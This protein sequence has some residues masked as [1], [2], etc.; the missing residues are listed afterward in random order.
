MT[1]PS[2]KYMYSRLKVE[3]L[4][5]EL[6]L[7]E[8]DYFELEKIYYE[9]PP[10]SLLK[11]AMRWTIRNLFLLFLLTLFLIASVLYITTSIPERP[12]FNQI[13][14]TSV[15][16]Q[17]Q[18]EITATQTGDITSDGDSVSI[19]VAGSDVVNTDGDDFVVDSGSLNVTIG[20]DGGLNV[21]VA[22]SNTTT[23][24]TTGSGSTNDPQSSAPSNSTAGSST[25]NK[26]PSS[27]T[28]ANQSNSGSSASKN[29]TT[30]RPPPS[31][32]GKD[33]GQVSIQDPIA[34]EQEPYTPIKATFFSGVDGPT[35]CRGHV[36]AVIQMPKP[37]VSGVPTSLQCYNFPNL[38][39]SGCGTFM[40]NKVDGCIA[41]FFEEPNCRT[42][43]NTAAFMP[44]NRAV[45]G[46]WRSA[47]VQ[48][49]VPEPDPESLGKPPMV[50]QISSLVDNDRA[51]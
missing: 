50:D 26:P 12:S 31:S 51:G 17:K 14:R 45:G 16:P 33:G 9:P 37:R 21:Q 5:L 43:V 35:H 39:Y 47:Q 28:G 27:S 40:A 1:G 6:E 11:L 36:I 10:P 42:Y 48:C 4:D 7:P 22:P 8:P 13:L 25:S 20:D 15:P 23:I 44:E 34:A 19:D 3:E 32:G 29:T 24:T 46:R 41:N 38:A 30:S 49:G 18:I 2:S